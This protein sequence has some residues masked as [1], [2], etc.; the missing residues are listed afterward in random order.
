M[1]LLWAN[2]VFMQQDNAKPH[3]DHN[4]VACIN[5]FGDMQHPIITLVN[6]PPQSPELNVNDLGFFYSLSK[7]VQ[8]SNSN[9]LDELWNTIEACYRNALPETLTNIWHTK[10]VTIQ[11]IIRVGGSSVNIPHT[12]VRAQNQEL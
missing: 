10:S 11:E 7:A 2:H 4:N 1:C 5:H 12:G 3:V 6:Q 8:K 9:T